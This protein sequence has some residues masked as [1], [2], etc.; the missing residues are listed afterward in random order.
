MVIKIS[1][2]DGKDHEFNYSIYERCYVCKT[3]KSQKQLEEDP[4]KFEEIAKLMLQYLQDMVYLCD[5]GDAVD[6]LVR[7]VMNLVYLWKKV[8]IP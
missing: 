6:P 1:C 5:V 2:L 7:W 8:K 4:D 3:C